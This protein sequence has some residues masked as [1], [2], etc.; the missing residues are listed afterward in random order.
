VP[1]S[2]EGP[3]SGETKFDIAPSGKYKVSYGDTTKEVRVSEIA[4]LK[5]EE[6][7]I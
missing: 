5:G 1:Y 2:T 6:V 7:K 3:V 4:V